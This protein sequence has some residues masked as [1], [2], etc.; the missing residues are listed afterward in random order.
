M[1]QPNRLT[2]RFQRI[3]GLLR[4]HWLL[5]STPIV[6][7]T[8]VAVIYALV[9]QPAWE[10]SQTLLVRD[11]AVGDLRR[12]G[13]FDST[14]AMKSAQETVLEI[15]RN[16][17]VVSR[18]L[19]EIGPPTDR[20]KQTD[21][22][23]AR[24]VEDAQ[25]AIRV[26]APPGAEFGQTELIY[27][28][29]RQPSRDR[30]LALAGAV[31]RALQDRLQQLRER[32]AQSLIAELEDTVKLAQD[33]LNEATRRL[34]DME[35]RVGSDL[36]E[37]RMLNHS[38]TG[39]SN[40]RSSLNQLK[41]ELRAARAALM[42]N[43]QQQE[44]LAAALEDPGQLVATPN[45]L[46]E[47]Q[48]ALRRLKDGLVDAQLR[49]AEMMGKMSPDHPLVQA[50]VTGEREVRQHLHG[51]LAV[52]LRGAEADAKVTRGQIESL[53]KQ[54]AEVRERLDKLASLRAEY[55]NLVAEVGDRTE[56]LNRAHQALSDARAS[57]RAALSTSL[58]TLVDAPQTGSRPTG[59]GKTALA[60]GGLFGGIA[61]AVGL[62]ILV[63]PVD[64][65]PGR[66]WYDRLPFRRR[67]ED[68]VGR[69]VSDIAASATGR[70][71][72][73]RA[74]SQGP[75]AG[76]DAAS[77]QGPPFGRRA[78]DMKYGRRADDAP[79][80]RRAE[81]QMPARRR[82][83]QTSAP[84]ADQERSQQ[85]STDSASV[86]PNQEPAASRRSSPP[87]QPSEETLEGET[88]PRPVL[89]LAPDGHDESD[90]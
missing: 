26:T 10:A 8:A 9:R 76:P 17:K 13:R 77:E 67:A 70:R 52:A 36:G 58:V 11:E 43:Q 14:E 81:D 87:Q 5:W 65:S 47:S 88:R 48:P 84:A 45:Q 55:G 40:L 29:V 32:R 78:D 86:A 79:P 89:S 71:A 50:A 72:E 2:A 35:T 7:C 49:T 39:D 38:G 75:A 16:P 20:A 3:T 41:E 18:A 69:R 74:A 80:R 44:L 31:G 57:Q 22:P 30:A 1:S 90:G 23:D 63:G 59:P 15:A 83:D 62:L 6:V 53:E 34:R 27:L 54:L 85:G 60:A 25:E 56:T 51:E 24:D 73:D 19:A 42:A 61:I 64:G 68:R 82:E 12:Q 21:W 33:D 66:R 4:R 46:L 37:L 28:S